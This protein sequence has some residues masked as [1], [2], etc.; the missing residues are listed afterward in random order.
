MMTPLYIFDLD[1]TIAKVDRRHALAR[2]DD[3]PFVKYEK[4]CVHDEPNEPVIDTMTRLIASRAEIWIFSGRSDKHRGRTLAWLIQHTRFA[5]WRNPATL[6]MRRAPAT[7]A[8][9]MS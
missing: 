7:R 1:G 8:R 4:E 2:D 3:G 9:T 6:M 5:A